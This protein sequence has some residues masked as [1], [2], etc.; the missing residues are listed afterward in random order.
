MYC[1]GPERLT[2]N[3]PVLTHRCRFTPLAYANTVFEKVELPELENNMR[4][5]IIYYNGKSLK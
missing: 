3:Q 2:R 4:V 5:E 1:F